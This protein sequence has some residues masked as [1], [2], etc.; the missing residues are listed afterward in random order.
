M[1]TLAGRSSPSW[2]AP[3]STQLTPGRLAQTSA[4]Q[5]P[6]SGHKGP[7]S[8]PKPRPR[9]CLPVHGGGGGAP[10]GPPEPGEPQGWGGGIQGPPGLSS[11]SGQ[12]AQGSDRPSPHPPPPSTFSRPPGPPPHTSG[13]HLTAARSQTRSPVQGPA[14]SRTPLP[15]A[16]SV[17]GLGWVLPGAG[18][19]GAL[20]PAGEVGPAHRPGKV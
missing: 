19:P 11:L 2:S 1:H 12:R 5:L 3:R 16:P 9:S 17:W 15:A 14:V 10:D 18:R 6:R 8:L 13:A 20:P 4:P 7:L